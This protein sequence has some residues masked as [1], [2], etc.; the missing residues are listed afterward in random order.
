MDEKLE[1]FL[2][3]L[4]SIFNLKENMNNFKY[5]PFREQTKLVHEILSDFQ[6]NIIYKGP[7][8]EMSSYQ[9]QINPTDSSILKLISYY[10][11]GVE[12]FIR[13]YFVYQLIMS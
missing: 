11:T 9:I 1:N 5:F 3:N 6:N 12:K 10:K 7:L 2:K 13:K 8:D 4:V